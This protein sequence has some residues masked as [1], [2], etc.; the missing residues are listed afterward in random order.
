MR[1]VLSIV[2]ALVLVVSMFAGCASKPAESS[3]VSSGAASGESSEAP[4][5]GNKD[6]KDIT[7]A[8]IPKLTGNAFFESAN[9][10]AQELAK[11]VGFACDYTGNPEA[12]VANQV[13]VI[14][15]A[16]QQGSDAI[17]IS[18]VTPDGLNQALK[19]ARDAGVKVVTW[20]SDVQPDMRSLM[21]SQG[22]PEQLGEM[23]VEMAASQMDAEQI[24][25]AKYV[26]HY[27]SSTVT[28]QNSWQVAGE[29]YIKSKYP[30]WQNVAPENYYSEQDAEKAV[31]VGESILKAHPDIDAI[32]CNDSTALPG[33][34]QAAKNLGLSGKVIVTGF[35]SPNSMRDFCKDGTVPKFGLWDCKIQGAMGAYLAYWLAAGNTFKVGDSID[36]PDIGTVKVE[37]NSV[38]DPKAYTA[39]DSGIVLLP[40]RTVF[41]IENVDNYDF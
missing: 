17:A 34:A 19:A 37:P 5:A 25:D 14:N 24:K 10:G 36:I 3:A 18:S 35:A 6:A 22:T 20:D 11:K 9:V 8:F 27:S 41:T 4:A 33:Q 40:E 30:G 2:L 31:S 23:L 12:S 15:S 16:V 29:A 32:I 1:K 38:L 39:D 28:D 13:Q 7:V 21:V 26:W